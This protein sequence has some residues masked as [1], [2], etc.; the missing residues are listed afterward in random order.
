M[1]EPR[2]VEK[3]S[4]T[5]AGVATAGQLGEFN[6]AEIW[7]KQYAPLAAAL[8]PFSLDGGAYGITLPEG[9]HLIYLAG[10]AV[11]DPPELPQ[12]VVKRQIAGAKYAV[13]DCTLSTMSAVMQEVFGQWF[14]ASPYQPDPNAV[15]F[16]YYLPFTGQGEMQVQIFV[17]ILPKEPVIT[18]SGDVPM[19][20][21]ETIS[22]RRSIRQFK[23][24]PI[25]EET[26]RQILQAG[27]LAPSGKNR[28]PWKFYVVQGDKHAEMI[29][30]M[31]A[32]IAHSESQG[33]GTGS[34]KNTLAVME[35]A[36]VTVFIFHPFGTP[37]WSPRSMGERFFDLVDVQSI[38]AA[39]QN[40]I[41]AAEELGLGSLWICDVFNAYEE[42]R[43][44]LG[45][46]SA[47]IAAVSFGV[48]AE[49]PV[50]RKRKPF[51]EVVHWVK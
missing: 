12:G 48:P 27:M 42:L 15:V 5:L 22:N 37:P 28:Q 34:A 11:A 44:W 10:I 25:P 23:S 41:L 51:D 7:E 49:H 36:P 1:Q 21:F 8:K 14:H 39:I 29:A 31:R 3:G 46:D 6:Y 38:G 2:F 18:Q 20:V 17:P 9:D 16:E 19:T 45:E 40:M 26:L 33:E 50:A 43:T 47:L 35:Q 30:Q 24:D 32:G 13:F 4:F